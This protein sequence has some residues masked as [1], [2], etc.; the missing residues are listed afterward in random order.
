M[1]SVID[2]NRDLAEVCRLLAADAPIDPDLRQRIEQQADA[3][4][5]EVFEKHGL[6]DV[7]TDL[8]RDARERA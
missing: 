3:I 8:V 1:A 6:L 2:T 5:R 7:A 4:R